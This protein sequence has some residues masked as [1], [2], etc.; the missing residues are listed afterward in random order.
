MPQ[1][2][3]APWRARNKFTGGFREARTP[4]VNLSREQV[5]DR[6]SR[7]IG[8]VCFF[9]GLPMCLEERFYLRKPVTA[10]KGRFVDF[11]GRHVLFDEGC[12][13]GRLR[14]VGSRYVGE[15]RACVNASAT[16]L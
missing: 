11:H 14:E 8:A 9:G 7:N 13:D 12:E 15:G 1:V 16:V 4:P 6:V 2:A 5:E 3:W 10:S